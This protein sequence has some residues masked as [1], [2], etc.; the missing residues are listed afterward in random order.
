MRDFSSE[1]RFGGQG[2]WF[3]SQGE[4]FGFDA[5]A[6]SGLCCFLPVCSRHYA[7]FPTIVL[8]MVGLTG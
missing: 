2:E 6:F 3:G 1:K 5:Q 8:S 4:W 7:L